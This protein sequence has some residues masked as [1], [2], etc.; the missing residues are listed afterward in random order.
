V[1]ADRALREASPIDYARPFA[2]KPPDR[3]VAIGL[4]LDACHAGDHRSCWTAMAV[5]PDA[6]RPTLFATVATN[7]RA[8]DMMSCRALP[9]D[10]DADAPRFPDL[11]GALGRGCVGND[12]DRAALQ[13]ECVAGFPKSCRRRMGTGSIPNTDLPN[14]TRRHELSVVGCTAGI[15]DECEE[16]GFSDA[17]AV[18]LAA[19]HQG[20]LL[21]RNRCASLGKY[22]DEIGLEEPGHPHAIDA[23]DAYERGCQYGTE[24]EACYNLGVGYILQTYPEPVKGRG[25]AVLGYACEQLAKTM[26]PQDLLAGRSMCKF[27]KKP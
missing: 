26:T 18:A 20:C 21:D 27:G 7:C 4:Y 1:R 17:P 12:C 6:Q 9:P 24:M 13:A 23:R 15:V 5:M 16:A 22:L 19:Y 10:D 25:A 8:G 14:E 11:P 2:N 3:S